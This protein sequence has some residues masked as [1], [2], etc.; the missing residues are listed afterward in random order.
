M[1]LLNDYPKI[2]SW[3]V[4]K[5]A[6][7]ETI[8]TIHP[9]VQK[10]AIL[11]TIEREY[12]LQEI[13]VITRA[14]QAKSLGLDKQRGHLGRGALADVVVYNFDPKVHDPSKEYKMLEKAFSHAEYV[15]KSGNL[16]IKKKLIDPNVFTGSTLWVESKVN[17]DLIKKTLDNLETKLERYSSIN[18]TNLYVDSSYIKNSE[19]VMI[20]SD[21]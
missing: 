17:E 19:K 2:I 10:N 15:I 18:T 20:Q 13:A 14:S 21:L 4:S 9:D 1:G 16:I 8:G 11:P 3:L 7:D 6:R 12:T 5:P